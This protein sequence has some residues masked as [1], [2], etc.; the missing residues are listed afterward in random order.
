MPATLKLR[1]IRADSGFFEDA[2]LSFLEARAIPYIVVARLTQTVKR[3]A[4]DLA[5][6]TPID[7]NHAWARFSLKLQGWAEPRE[8]FAIRERVRENK[9][10]VGRRL[11]EVEGYTFRV[12]V[13]NRPGDGA[14][15]WRDYNQRACIEQHKAGFRRPATLRAAM[16]IGGAVLG[17]RSR[18][19]VLYIAESW[20]GLD[21]HKPLMENILQW[22][23]A[24]SPTL[25]PEPPRPPDAD[26]AGLPSTAESAAAWPKITQLRISGLTYRASLGAPVGAFV[27]TR[28]GDP[29]RSRHGGV[30]P[31]CCHQHGYGGMAR[32]R[33]RENAG[34]RPGALPARRSLPPVLSPAR[35][36]R[37]GAWARS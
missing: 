16:F 21:K 13:T 2:L 19:P 10:A 11:I 4:A 17:T 8:F 14:E 29:V 26:Q 20:G 24:T 35:L 33:V 9:S 27:R 1:T 32:G 36:R 6:W 28:A 31:P 15:L 34:G 23:G 37:N 5:T 12:F 7:E 22:P 18:T 3:K 25:P 30:C